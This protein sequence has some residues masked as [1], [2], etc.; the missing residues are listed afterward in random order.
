[1]AKPVIPI[2]AKLFIGVIANSDDV[3]NQ[4]ERIIEKKFGK[5]DYK[6]KKIPFSHTE[7]YSYMGSN[8]FKVFFSFH[9]LFKREDIVVIKLL[10]NKLEK[11]IS[12][13]EKRRVNIDPGYL[14]LS[15]VYLAT[16]KD[17]FHRVY[18]GRG[19]Y[20]ENEYKYVGKNFQ[21]WEWTYPDYRKHEY[22]DF[23][24]NMRKLYRKQIKEG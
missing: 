10:A 12:G 2:K 3:L 8:L 6:T 1:M 7:Y 22:L 16:C 17:F 18:I 20:L 13:N 9:R 4:A 19:V 11:K 23:F 15:N 14:T 24:Y 21:P 5:I